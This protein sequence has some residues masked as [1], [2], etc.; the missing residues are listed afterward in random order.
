VNVNTAMNEKIEDLYQ[1]IAD[2]LFDNIPVDFK[3]AWISVE[4]Q[5]DFGSTR[6]IRRARKNLWINEYLGDVEID[7]T[8]SSADTTT[9]R[10]S[11][12]AWL[13][14]TGVFAPS[15]VPVV[16][17]G[18]CERSLPLRKQLQEGKSCLSVSIH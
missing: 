12:F 3:K 8:Q 9:L 15:R 7:C 6:P 18:Q 2:V 4:M 17:L 10:S 5:E 13:C 14:L 1:Q 16:R 11:I